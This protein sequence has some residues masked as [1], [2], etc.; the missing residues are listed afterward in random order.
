[1]SSSSVDHARPFMIK[2][3][4]RTVPLGVSLEN[5][6]NHDDVPRD[7]SRLITNFGLGTSKASKIFSMLPFV[8][9]NKSACCERDVSDHQQDRQKRERERHSRFRMSRSRGLIE[10][11]LVGD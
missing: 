2:P 9:D 6:S 3:L 4:P 1:M 8:L 5:P 7:L 10:M 11:D